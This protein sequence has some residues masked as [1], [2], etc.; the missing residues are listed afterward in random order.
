MSVRSCSLFGCCVCA[1]RN[2][3]SCQTDLWRGSWFS[4]RKQTLSDY[5]KQKSAC[6][7]E[8]YLLHAYVREPCAP[9]TFLNLVLTFPTCAGVNKVVNHSRCGEQ[10]WE[11]GRS[12]LLQPQA[13]VKLSWRSQY[14]H[15]ASKLV[16]F[17][18][19]TPVC[20]EASLSMSLAGAELV[21]NACHCLE[22]W[23]LSSSSRFYVFRTRRGSCMT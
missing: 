20:T 10:S 18:Y 4:P 22:P 17:W 8:H 11:Q 1:R 14:L 16:L 13:A 23:I 9:L 2:S 7:C 6:I 19:R 15:L 21:L 5:Q 12:E 3:S